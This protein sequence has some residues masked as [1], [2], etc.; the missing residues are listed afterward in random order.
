MLFGTT[1]LHVLYTMVLLIG[2]FGI[3]DLLE[4]A[5]GWEGMLMLNF[6]VVQLILFWTSVLLWWSFVVF[7]WISPPNKYLYSILSNSNNGWSFRIC[8]T[9]VEFG[10]SV[11]NTFIWQWYGRE[12]HVCAVK[13]IVMTF[14][15]FFL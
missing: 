14:I 3:E 15:E 6:S 13:W 2:C 7:P 1:N 4:R 11:K 12:L 9:F 5:C 10:I 8:F